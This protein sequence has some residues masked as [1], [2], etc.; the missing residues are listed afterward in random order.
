MSMLDKLVDKLNESQG[1]NDPEYEALSQEHCRAF[2]S[3][4]SRKYKC[5]LIP[6]RSGGYRRIAQP[7]HEL[8]AYQRAF[9]ELYPFP[10]HEC[11]MGYVR[12]RSIKD[13][14]ECHRTNPYLLKADL[15]NFFNSIKPTMFWQA[16]EW[17]SN[18]E[19]AREIVSRKRHLEDY[20]ELFA[21]KE[22][23]EELLFWRPGKQAKKLILSI[24]APS[25]PMISNFCMFAFDQQMQK[26]CR[27]LGIVYSRY[28]DDLTFSTSKRD[29]LPGFISELRIRLHDFFGGALVLN[30][31]KTVLSSKAH[32]RRI[33]GVTVTNDQRL[34]VG[35]KQ[36]RYVKHLVHAFIQQK[37][38]EEEF[39]YLKGYLAFVRHVE[40][41]FLVSLSEK[42]S[43]TVI[44]QLLR[45]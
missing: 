45:S 10:V 38:T 34:S 12:G 14:A 36:K 31:E 23:V 8:K 42:Y 20:K 33:T 25:S 43:L 18:E 5:Y 9:L 32:N 13:N 19:Q 7:S 4:A 39:C 3:N 41:N 22:L 1:K 40:P 37:L 6:K 27:Q 17:L 21:E 44:N 35:R 26:R 24:G 11:A 15:A 29:L 16:L 30:P 28:V 2:L